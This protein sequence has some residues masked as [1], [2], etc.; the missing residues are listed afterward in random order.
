MALSE[1]F[2]VIETLQIP[3]YRMEDTVRWLCSMSGD[4]SVASAW[5]EIRRKMPIAPWASIVWHKNLLPRHSTLGWRLAHGKMPTDVEVQKRGVCVVSRCS[6]CRK[7]CESTAHLFL[8]CKF[9]DAVWNTFADWFGFIWG[10]PSSILDFLE[11]W[12]GKLR[13]SN[14]RDLWAVGAIVV[15]A[16]LWEERNK[17]CHEGTH[18][19]MKQLLECVKGELQE[20]K[21][22]IRGVKSI[23]DL[24]VK[25]IGLVSSTD[26]GSGIL[27]VFWCKPDPNWVKLNIDGSSL[28]NPGKAGLG[29]GPC[30]ATTRPKWCSRMENT[31]AFP[32]AS[33]L[34]LKL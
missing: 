7:E 27:E 12:K 25:T 21:F 22:V 19:S 6:L 4:F 2:Q 13:S 5:E 1:A 23:Q 14:L 26:I 10:R 3:N 18:R 11:W 24:C 33:K 32:I 17:R 16:T 28:G 9:S 29:W 30:F 8:T 15:C 20:C 31:W 34:K